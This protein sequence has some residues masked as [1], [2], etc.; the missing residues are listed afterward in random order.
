MS[1]SSTARK[2]TQKNQILCETVSFSVESQA[3]VK[4]VLFVKLN[5][6]P[7]ICVI[8]ALIGHYDYCDAKKVDGN[9]RI[10]S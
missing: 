8:T 7:N 3:S 4:H 9:C 1:D 5:I 6:S 10:Y 2:E